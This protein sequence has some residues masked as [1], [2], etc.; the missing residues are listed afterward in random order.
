MNKFVVSVEEKIVGNA[1]SVEKFRI[2]SNVISSRKS[3][4]YKI[5]RVR[6][7]KI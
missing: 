4:D 7:T 5:K 2:I 3:K 6:D 1:F